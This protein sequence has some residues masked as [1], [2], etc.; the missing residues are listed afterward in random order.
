MCICEAGDPRTDARVKATVISLSEGARA[1]TR[2]VHHPRPRGVRGPG[3]DVPCVPA[4]SLR[5]DG[6]VPAAKT[7]ADKDAFEAALTHAASGC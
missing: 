7:R 1:M 3:G 5:A 4:G 2:R 6:A